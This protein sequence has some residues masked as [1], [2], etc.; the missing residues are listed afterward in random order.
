M[1]H[2][3]EDLANAV[4]LQAMEDYRRA[5]RILRRNPRSR[6]GKYLKRDTLRFF[7][8]RWFTRLTGAPRG[9]LVRLL[10][11]EDRKLDAELR[12]RENCFEWEDNQ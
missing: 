10:L 5:Q 8:S 2:S 12:E 7:C 9:V 1:K 11:E 3:W 4:V 6:R